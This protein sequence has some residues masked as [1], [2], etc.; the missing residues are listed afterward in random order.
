MNVFSLFRY[1]R[2]SAPRSPFAL[3]IRTFSSTSCHLAK[4]LPPRPKP[5]PES[6]IE[7]A[8][9]KGSGPGGQ[10]IVLVKS[11]AT[12]SR[13]QNRK[14]A[15]ELLAQRIDEFHNGDQSRSAIVGRVK[16]KKAASVSKKSRRKY[17]KLEEE[18]AA[19][20]AESEV[21]IEV[22]SDLST[23]DTGNR[24]RP[25]PVQESI[26]PKKEETRKE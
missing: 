15:R 21:P 9:V 26:E 23:E 24:T 14:H 17:K 11:Q 22:T 3:P 18:K 19:A 10:K 1:I 13:D 5:P 20:A 6:E 7:E 2:P 12:R 25:D 4:A 8:Y 16:E